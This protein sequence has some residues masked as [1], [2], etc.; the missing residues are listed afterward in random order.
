MGKFSSISPI[1]STILGR[2]NWLPRAMLL[3]V[4]DFLVSLGKFL[5]IYFRNWPHFHFWASEKGSSK[6]KI[7]LNPL[8]V[9]CYHPK[10][11][12]CS[13]TVRLQYF[14]NFDRYLQ[15]LLD[16]DDIG[17]AMHTRFQTIMEYP[18]TTAE[19][20]DKISISPHS[21]QQDLKLSK[22]SKEVIRSFGI[23]RKLEVNYICHWK[24]VFIRE[25]IIYSRRM[26]LL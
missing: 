12:N 23:D 19:D 14:L 22:K 3:N 8:M 5:G 24:N 17:I 25:Q 15:H 2:P 11:L 7:L 21:L 4:F 13:K 16:H 10:C 9:M 1:F 20:L 6:F 18:F 26:M